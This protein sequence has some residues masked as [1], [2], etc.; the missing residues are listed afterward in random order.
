MPA[1]TPEAIETVLGGG[2]TG[3][4]AMAAEKAVKTKIETNELLLV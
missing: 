3:C 1:I 2:A 4:W